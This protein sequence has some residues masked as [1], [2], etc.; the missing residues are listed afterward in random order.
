MKK[1]NFI[2]FCFLLIIF[3]SCNARVS[4]NIVDQSAG[5]IEASSVKSKI[6][7]LTLEEGKSGLELKIKYVDMDNT[8]REERAI[9][10]MVDNAYAYNASMNFSSTNKRFSGQLNC[11][12]TTCSNLD[13][14]LYFVGDSNEPITI[15]QREFT[16]DSS[17]VEFT[18]KEFQTNGDTLFEAKSAKSNSISSNLTMKLIT[19]EGIEMP[20]I[21][22][23]SVKTNGSSY[24]IKSNGVNS[25][26]SLDVNE[27]VGSD[28]NVKAFNVGGYGR[29]YLVLSNYSGEIIIDSN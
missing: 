22:I 16:L 4:G 20:L 14:D 26:I 3:I 29:F 23:E 27:R 24:R 21:N 10:Q 12:N 19:I 28:F 18:A 11:K 8:F 1:T 13:V 25:T 15:S 17:K 2:S 7:D 9:I 6:S 5:L